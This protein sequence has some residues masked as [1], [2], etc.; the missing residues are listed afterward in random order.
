MLC[1][2]T[3]LVAHYQRRI[4]GSS[5]SQRLW[6]VRVTVGVIVAVSVA[7]TVCVIVGVAVC[8]GV[9]VALSV[10]VGV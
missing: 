5:S 7:V 9:G 4:S 2:D 1:L 10:A 3:A 6:M 8:E